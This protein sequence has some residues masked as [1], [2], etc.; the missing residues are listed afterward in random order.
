MLQRLSRANVCKNTTM[1]MAAGPL[2]TNHTPTI[3]SIIFAT[4]LMFVGKRWLHGE[5]NIL[6]G[7][8]FLRFRDGKC[9]Q[10]SQNGKRRT[11]SLVSGAKIRNSTVIPDQCKATLD[12]AD[13]NGWIPFAQTIEEVIA[14]KQTPQLHPATE[15]CISAPPTLTVFH[16]RARKMLLFKGHLSQHTHD[17]SAAFYYKKLA[18]AT[19]IS[20]VFFFGRLW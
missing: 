20:V 11:F 1:H 2:L 3:A 13:S 17:F 7:K 5:E 10:A 9:F 14:A 16:W 19:A 18:S 4:K 8:C 12:V 15:I 6:I